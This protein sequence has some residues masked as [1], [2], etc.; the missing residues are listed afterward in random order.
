[1]NIR[2][3]RDPPT[4]WEEK[5]CAK[6]HTADPYFIDFFA[7]PFESQ[8]D[9]VA[10]NPWNANLTDLRLAV[11][12]IQSAIKDLA[13]YCLKPEVRDF[14]DRMFSK[15]DEETRHYFYHHCPYFRYLDPSKPAQTQ[16]FSCE[17]R[18]YDKT[19]AIFPYPLRAPLR[20][21]NTL[22]TSEED[23]FLHSVAYV[24]HGAC[25]FD[26]ANSIR[27]LRDRHPFLPHDVAILLD[28][29]YL[30]PANQF[31]GNGAKYP[32]LWDTPALRL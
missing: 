15:P 11:Y 22:L 14:I 2:V 25:M 21:H 31:D 24:F 13:N 6:A 19:S 30:T 3:T 23:E 5:P 4:Q 18:H 10:F 9:E 32:L 12:Y 8:I 28:A 17:C 29:G 16:G 20:H 26:L 7:N 1:M 27:E